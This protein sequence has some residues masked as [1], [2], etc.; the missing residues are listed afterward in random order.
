MG[1]SGTQG[2]VD[3]GNVSFGGIEKLLNYYETQVVAFQLVF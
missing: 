1:T 2:L 3:V